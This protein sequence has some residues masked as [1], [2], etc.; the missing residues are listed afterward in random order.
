MAVQTCSHWAFGPTVHQVS[1]HYDLAV[2]C[3]WLARVHNSNV[4]FRPP[5]AFRALVQVV[6]RLPSFFTLCYIVKVRLQ[7]VEIRQTVRQLLCGSSLNSPSWQQYISSF[8][9]ALWL[10][11]MHIWYIGLP[12]LPVL[13]N[14]QRQHAAVI[15]IF[16]SII[17][18]SW[19]LTLHTDW[20]SRLPFVSAVRTAWR[21]AYWWQFCQ[22]RKVWNTELTDLCSVNDYCRREARWAHNSST[23]Y[24]SIR[25]KQ[26][27]CYRLQHNKP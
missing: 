6:A 9:R 23:E 22:L 18:I 16:M 7:R 24:I 17:A 12:V 3:P 2:V 13:L 4:K 26:T 8:Q 25:A 20:Q 1:H 27:Y 5:F 21:A 11:R 19:S 15:D 14:G 10:S